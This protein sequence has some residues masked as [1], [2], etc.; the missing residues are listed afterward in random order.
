MF[1]RMF[2]ARRTAPARPQQHHFMPRVSTAGVHITEPTALTL[3]PVWA[4]VKV[5][6]ETVAQLPWRVFLEDGNQRVLQAG[7]TLDV[8]LHRKPNEE[9]TPF[10]FREFM[11]A[12]ALLHGNGYAE[13]ELSRISEPRGLH[14]IHPLRVQPMRNGK[15]ML[16]YRIRSENGEVIDL[17]PR[18]IYHLRG[19]TMDGIVGRS[20]ISIAR[21]SMGL[22]IATEQFSSAFFG[23]G[24]TPS[25][26]IQQGADS[27]DTSKE[28][29]ENILESFD[30]RHKG[31]HKA[32]KPA[33][34]ERGFELKTVG[35]PQ[36]DAQFIQQRKFNVTEIARWFRVPPHKIADMDK[37]TFSNIESQE[38]NFVGDSILPWTIR[39]E[40]EANAKLVRTPKTST[41][42]NVRGLMRGDSQARSEFYTKMRD[43]G[44]LDINEIR[45]LED[46][47]PISGGDLRL[48]PL[49]M[50]S[51]NRAGAGG[52]TDPA[53]AVRGVLLEAH[54]RMITKEDRAAQRAKDSS[55]DIAAWSQEFYTRHEPQMRDALMVPASAAGD[56]YGVGVDVVRGIVETHARLHC[57]LSMIGMVDGTWEAE[58]QA[59]QQTDRLLGRL[60]GA[61]DV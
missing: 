1:D 24:G 14:P 35:I 3:S 39:M 44:A 49:N 25:Y 20:V 30:R 40:Q 38:R 42:M 59:A 29:A 6:S 19:P 10:T 4:A 32:G 18:H 5:I 55:K 41:K 58:H 56:L 45:A 34:L 33:Y 37:A 51:I 22:G 2:A 8:I 21:E 15:N 27:P 36:K 50:V 61:S 16:V 48:V 9:M 11:I 7:T 46:M 31:A 53:G 23:N 13:I 52:G 17:P 60:I 12:S 28:A 47:N 57:E 43:L 26:V 54:E